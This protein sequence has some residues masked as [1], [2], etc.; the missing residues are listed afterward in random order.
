[1]KK[2]PAKI[3]LFGEHTV[4]LGS[5]LEGINNLYAVAPLSGPADGKGSINWIEL[6]SAVANPDPAPEALDFLEWIT[7]P[8]PAVIIANGNGNLQ[9]VSQMAQPEVLRQFS[10]K[11]LAALQWDEFDERIANAV[12]FDIVPDYDRLYDIYS[13]AIRERA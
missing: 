4:N 9:P 8:E 7:K 10:L 3:L 13:A 2:Y 11:Q 5:R 1:M 6:N 12:E